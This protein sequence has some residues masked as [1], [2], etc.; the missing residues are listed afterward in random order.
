MATISASAQASGGTDGAVRPDAALLQRAVSASGGVFWRREPASGRLSWGPGLAAIIGSEPPDGTDTAG[1]WRERLHPDDRERVLD[2]LA[3]ALAEADAA[4]QC[5]YRLVRRDGSYAH[6]R[7]GGAVEPGAGG[8]ASAMVGLLFDDS[9]RQRREAVISRK[10]DE[11]YGLADNMP[12]LVWMAEGDGH[13]FWYNRRWYEYTGFTPEELEGWGWEAAH[14]PDFLPLVKQRWIYSLEHGEPFDMTF[15]LRG[16]DGS[17]RPFLTR[18][19]PI[20]DHGGQVIRWFGSCTDVSEQSRR[21][22]ALRVHE[23]I[24]QQALGVARMGVF[25]RDLETGALF[26][27]R[28]ARDL[29]GLQREEVSLEEYAASVD[30]R[31]RAKFL[32]AIGAARQPGGSGLSFDDHRY[33]RADGRLMWVHHE[34]KTFFAGE[35]E[36]R[37]AVRSVGIVRD[38]TAERTDQERLLVSE[39]RLRDLFESLYEGFLSGEVIGGESGAGDFVIRSAN[40]EWVR[41]FGMEGGELAGRRI[42]EL[43]EDEGVPWI[44]RLCR[45]AFADQPENFELHLP[46]SKRWFEVRAYRTQPGQ[47]AALFLD[48]SDRKLAQSEAARAQSDLLRISRLSAMGAMASTL[49]HEINQPLAACA[50]YLAVVERGLERLADEQAAA[51]AGYVEKASRSC[52]KAGEIIRRIR[53]FTMEGEVVRT[54]ENLTDIALDAVADARLHPWGSALQFKVDTRPLFVMADRTQL[55]Q[56]LANLIRNSAEALRE[57]ADGEI[58]IALATRGANVVLRFSDNGPGLSDDAVEH[59]FEP[60]RSDSSR[61]MGLGLSLCRTIIEAHDGRISVEEPGDGGACFVISLPAAAPPR[62]DGAAD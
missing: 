30:E 43:W 8:E 2:T 32:A 51:L 27:S 4:W 13:V 11:V 21:E 20:R 22:D 19:I 25:D 3:A 37:R 52:Q 45:A 56:V 61:G 59:L 9:E 58:R 44:R 38:I 62:A 17:F 28:E 16:A 48:Q 14:H 40:P 1:W 24:L 35:G 34:S 53:G 6:V 12:A 42:S 36:D 29:L 50:N 7:D 15:P 5:E 54:R 31:D 57:R 18:G 26:V 39:Q 55:G 33:R 47:F 41:Q 49:A 10:R 23:E 60:F 46:G